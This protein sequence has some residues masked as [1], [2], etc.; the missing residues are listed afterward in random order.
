MSEDIVSAEKPSE[1]RSETDPSPARAEMRE[2]CPVNPECEKA[3]A[4]I[5]EE[6]KRL[7]SY[8]I[9]NGTAGINIRLD[10]LEQSEMRRTSIFRVSMV[11]FG[12]LCS[13]ATISV[14]ALLLKA[15]SHISK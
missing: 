14:C 13:A 10:R 12:S 9:G 5:Q 4:I 3:F 8:L 1:I 15:W 7:R 6:M 2:M 11:I